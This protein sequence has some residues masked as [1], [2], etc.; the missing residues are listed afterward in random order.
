[1]VVTTAVRW[2]WI[3]NPVLWNSGQYN[4]FGNH[5]K[6]SFKNFDS[7]EKVIFC[8]IYNIFYRGLFSTSQGHILVSRS[9]D[10]LVKI[11]LYENE[12]LSAVIG[13]WR[14]SVIASSDWHWHRDISTVL[15]L[16]TVH[17][18]ILYCSNVSQ[19]LGVKERIFHSFW[20][21][22]QGHWF[23]WVLLLIGCLGT[24]EKW[25]KRSFHMGHQPAIRWPGRISITHFSSCFI[26]ALTFIDGP[27]TLS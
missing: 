13:M 2:C 20:L 22:Y 25:V 26:P 8:R 27:C 10:N 7:S 4:L 11:L 16:V 18:S 12:L 6:C 23:P 1:M 3:M 5:Q 21:H 9:V 15:S 17:V 14:L 24:R 19:L